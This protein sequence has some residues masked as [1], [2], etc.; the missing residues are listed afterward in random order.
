MNL[1]IL[2]VALLASPLVFTLI[3]AATPQSAGRPAFAGMHMASLS[4]VLGL[5]LAVGVPALVSGQAVDACGLWLHVDALSAIFVLLIGIIGF[6][7]GLFSLPYVRHDA[8]AGL[9]GADRVK[10]YYALYSLFVFTMLLAAASNNLILT[11]AAIEATTLSTVFLV[12][13]Y[14]NRDCLEASWKYAIVCTSGVAFGLFGTL[15]VYANAAD[16][17]ANPHEAAFFTAIMPYAGQFDPMLTKIAFAFALIG[18]GTKAGLFPMHTWLPDA[19]SQAPSPVSGLLSGVLLKVAILVII[20]FYMV[21]LAA[22]GALFPSVLLLTVGILSVVTSAFSL[23]RQHDIKRKFAYHSVENVGIIAVALGIG[24]PLG[25]A[26]ALLHCVFHGITKALLF[27]LSGNLLMTYGTRD[28]RRITGVI[29]VAPVT[30]TLLTVS[31]FGL[32]GFPP[33][34]MFVSETMTF[35]AGAS[36]H[37][38]WVVVVVALALTV[39]IAVIMQII[40]G[41]VLGHAPEGQAKGDV[42][43]LAL[44][45]EFILLACIVWFGVATPTPLVAGVEN[46]CAIVLQSDDLDALHTA[47]LYRAVFDSQAAAPQAADVQNG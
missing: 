41:S 22:V 47:P 46:S 26:A 42:E 5:S 31:L 40:S 34:A 1:S 33:L 43:P 21:A 11:W 38:L 17:M 44:V 25:V 20:R 13:I 3:M 45:P 12:G 9:M 32:A 30:A 27:C 35:V 24:G 23:V 37:L 39:V 2:L 8:E 6:L 14:R 18:F 15:L 16:V 10:Q 7:T 29:E 4:I 36:A 19:H 28:L